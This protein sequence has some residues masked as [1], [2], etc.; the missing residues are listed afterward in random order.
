MLDKT[1]T[2]VGSLSNDLLLNTRGKVK[3]KWGQKTIDLV[4]NGEIAQ[5]P[6]IFQVDSKDAIKNT[7]GIYYT[8]EG[9]FLQTGTDLIQ[10]SNKTAPV[11][12]IPEADEIPSDYSAVTI[13]AKTNIKLPTTTGYTASGEQVI[14]P[15]KIY[16][17]ISVELPFIEIDGSNY[18][19]IKKVNE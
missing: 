13:K 12:L 7:K 15:S 2:E 1:F 3:I 11:E 16:N 18:K 14:I 6:I 17:D 19:F 9:V 10:L 8:D 4:V 5:K